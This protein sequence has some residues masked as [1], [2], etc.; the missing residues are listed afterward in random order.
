M[1]LDRRIKMQLA[2]FTVIALIAIPIMLFGYVKLP[3]MLGIGRYTVTVELRAAGGLYKRG[4]VTYRGT[5]VGRIE[6]VRLTNT[7]VEALLSLN[8]D[9]KIPSDLDAE[10]HRLPEN[11]RHL[12]SD[13]CIFARHQLR[14]RMN[15]GDPAPE[16]A[17]HLPEFQSDVSPTQHK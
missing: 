4:N 9:T 6:E 15:D 13:I 10:V 12:F 14:L 3:E 5:E 11:L 8:S 17:E 2:I 1:R 7:G 16:P